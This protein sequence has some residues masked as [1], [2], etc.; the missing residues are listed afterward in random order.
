[1]PQLL[2]QTWSRLETY[3]QDGGV[4]MLPLVLVSLLMWILI[5]DRI[6]FFRRLYRKTMSAHSASSQKSSS[7]H[8]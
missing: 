4:V 7:F 5:M 6:F 3:L 8:S 1:M 2:E